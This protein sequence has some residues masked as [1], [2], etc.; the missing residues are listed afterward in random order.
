[1][2]CYEN[3]H[4]VI[5]HYRANGYGSVDS[6][7]EACRLEGYSYAGMMV[8]ISLKYIQYELIYTLDDV[9]V[10]KMSLIQMLEEL[11]WNYIEI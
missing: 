3:A 10:S 7:I 9:M 1:M 6:C 8:C 2:G 4:T 5:N 11:H